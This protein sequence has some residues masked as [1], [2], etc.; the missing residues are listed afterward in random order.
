MKKEEPGTDLE[1]RLIKQKPNHKRHHSHVRNHRDNSDDNMYSNREPPIQEFLN[2]HLFKGRA[3]NKLRFDNY[4]QTGYSNEFVSQSNSFSSNPKFTSAK[5][6]NNSLTP[7]QMRSLIVENVD[8][9]PRI[10]QDLMQNYR[11]NTNAD[12][13]HNNAIDATA[14][15]KSSDYKQTPVAFKTKQEMINMYQK[16]ILT[17]PQKRRRRLDSETIDSSKQFDPKAISQSKFRPQSEN[18]V[19]L[20]ESSVQVKNILI[21]NS[22]HINMPINF[23]QQNSKVKSQPSGQQMAEQKRELL[24]LASLDRVQIAGYKNVV[25]D[26]MTSN[27]S[28]CLPKSLHSDKQ[29]Q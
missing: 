17:D 28:S 5:N 2:S 13:Q 27:K 26:T 8:Q 18:L 21:D 1:Y 10:N 6:F 24:K 16:N 3:A 12:F 15:R 20:A 22:T 25:H 7:L 23:N 19:P 29:S 4:Q 9:Q 14:F 11:K